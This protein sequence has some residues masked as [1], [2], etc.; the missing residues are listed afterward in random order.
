MVFYTNSLVNQRNG[1]KYGCVILLFS[2]DMLQEELEPLVTDATNR[3]TLFNRSGETLFQY[4]N[5]DDKHSVLHLQEESRHI[6]WK[7]EL[8]ISAVGVSN[9]FRVAVL[10]V[11][12]FTVVLLVL[13]I[14]LAAYL[15]HNLA[16][17]VERI[18][19]HVSRIA[20]GD[21]SQPV[22]IKGDSEI[23]RLGRDYRSD[24]WRYSAP[25]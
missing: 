9:Q 8:Q 11:V 18:A 24:A 6:Q 1:E 13:I 4:E 16:A 3:L 10:S 5:E 15:S 25:D 12:T 23:S 21:F 2:V 22:S 17:P 19:A 14:L 7:A 20:K